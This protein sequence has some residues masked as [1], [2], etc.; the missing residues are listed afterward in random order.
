MCGCSI[1]PLPFCCWRIAMFGAGVLSRS[2]GN[3]FAPRAAAMLF[4]RAIFPQGETQIVGE[5]LKATRGFFVDVGANDPRDGSQTWHLE[6]RGWSGVLI[7]PQPDLAQRLRQ[8]R[9]AKVYDVA[10]STPANAGKS[11]PLH[12]AGIQSSLNA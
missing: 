4:E 12:L 3:S 9:R 6:Q 11:M 10:C 1:R 2:A 7:E 5:F 8:E